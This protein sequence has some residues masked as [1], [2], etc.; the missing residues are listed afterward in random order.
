MTDEELRKLMESLDENETD[1][2]FGNEPAPEDLLTEQRIQARVMQRV[3]AELHPE[4]IKKHRSFPIPMHIMCAAAACLVI[5]VSVIAFLHTRIT[6]PE[7]IMP[8]ST[9]THTTT[10][11]EAAE[12]ESTPILTETTP[13]TAPVTTE[14]ASSRIPA[15][16]VCT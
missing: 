10:I 4:P 12:T 11:S 3:R 8:D 7:I 6:A 16:S 14:T 1:L 2:L 13:H 5:A 15:L 9:T